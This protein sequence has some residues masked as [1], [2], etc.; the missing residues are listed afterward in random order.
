MNFY[1]VNEIFYS[2]Q[3]EGVRAGTTNVFVRFA[4][5]NLACDMVPSEKS[6]GGFMCDTEFSSSVKMSTEEIVKRVE[7]LTGGLACGVIFTG[8]EPS[9]Q[10]DEELVRAVAERGYETCIE[11]NGTGAIPEGLDWITVSPKTAEHTIKLE[12]CHEVKYVR[13]YGQ[14]IPRPTVKAVH[15]IISPAFE[16]GGILNQR[17][18]EWCIKLVKSHPGWRLSVQQHKSWGVR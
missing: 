18:L 8:G 15:K 10:L 1:A 4:G 9:L 5:C 13:Q 17:T 3:G 2:L 11:T 12:S 6:P 7:T 16:P 14:G